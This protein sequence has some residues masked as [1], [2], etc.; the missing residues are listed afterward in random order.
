MMQCFK[1]LFLL[2]TTIFVTLFSYS[3]NWTRQ[4]SK[5]KRDSL[6]AVFS[7]EAHDQ[8]HA[9]GGE[10]ILLKNG[11]FRYWEFYPL[12]FQEHAEGTYRIKKDT[13]TLTSDLQ[14]DNLKAI[15]NYVDSIGND[16]LYTRLRHPMN[17]KGDTLYNAY[18]FINNDTSVNGHY[19]PWFYSN[20]PPLTVV[21][22][23]KVMFYDTNW[24]SN[25]I[26]VTQPDKFLKVT[27][28]TD[29]DTDDHT[30]KV[31]KN[32]KFKIIGNRLIDLSKKK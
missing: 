12:N 11:R 6:F 25:W 13:L 3:Q 1:Y 14:S 23:L 28:L 10:I 4:P 5:A 30:Y 7:W 31:L 8:Y 9:A 17:K 20:I 27:V 22:S 2:A 18:Y 32:W 26:P 24:G 15:I 29:V 21:K 19:D 16:T